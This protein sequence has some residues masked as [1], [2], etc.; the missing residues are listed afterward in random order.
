MASG[1][2]RE[3][4]HTPRRSASGSP[5]LAYHRIRC[6]VCAHPDRDAV[7]QDFLHWA[8]PSAIT[9]EYQLGDRRA[10]GRHARAFG[11]LELRA[12]GRRRALGSIIE[13]AESVTATA[14]DIIRAVRAHA[15]L[16]ENGRRV[17]ITHRTVILDPPS[18]SRE[19]ITGTSLP[20]DPS[21]NEALPKSVALRARKSIGTPAD[22]NSA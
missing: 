21:L 9:H 8:R 16:D 3:T 20:C 15:C 11:L 22:R 10:I 1:S 6:T 2:D 4:V 5:D 17:I 14:N 7:E 19:Q 12:A 13:Q 18:R